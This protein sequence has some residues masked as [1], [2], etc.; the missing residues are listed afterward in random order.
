MYMLLLLLPLAA[1]ARLVRLVKW[2]TNSMVAAAGVARQPQQG[3]SGHHRWVACRHALSAVMLAV[4]WPRTFADRYPCCE[5]AAAARVMLAGRPSFLLS[6]CGR[7]C[8]CCASQATTCRA[9]LPGTMLRTCCWHVTWAW[10]AS[11]P[12]STST[13]T[14][15]CRWGRGR[16]GPA[17]GLPSRC[18]IASCSIMGEWACQR[19]VST[20]RVMVAASGTVL[21]GT[22]WPP[23]V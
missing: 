19:G 22:L 5:I 20:Y 12:S 6:A 21:C 9:A 16:A 3:P 15:T 18:M 1:A 2:I 10:P 14:R 8:P 7:S 11:T 13:T 23:A 17:V 4:P